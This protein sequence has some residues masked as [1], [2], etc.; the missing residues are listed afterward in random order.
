M[1]LYFLYYAAMGLLPHAVSEN[2]F[3]SPVGANASEIDFPEWNIG[4]E[5]IITW[6]A[7]YPT[8]TLSILQKYHLLD[9][10]SNYEIFLSRY[11]AVSTVRHIENTR[12][13]LWN[14]SSSL[15]EFFPVHREHADR[16]R[17]GQ[18]LLFSPF[19]WQY[20]QHHLHSIPILRNC[21]SVK[22][23]C[24]PNHDH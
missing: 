4:T 16:P 21:E 3:I 15:S 9:G 19:L 1:L 2:H 13:N 24:N 5:Q 20:L 18:R 11:I 8:I 17:L 10:L 12:L 14:R 7:D 23:L 6:S 22:W